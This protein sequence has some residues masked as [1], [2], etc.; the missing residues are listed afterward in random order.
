MTFK[1][2]DFGGWLMAAMQEFTGEYQKT[3]VVSGPK[4]WNSP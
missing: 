2:N 3:V 1:K 4:I